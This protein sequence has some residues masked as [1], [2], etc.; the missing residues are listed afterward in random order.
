[1]TEDRLREFFRKQKIKARVDHYTAEGRQVGFAAIGADKLP[2]LLFIHGAPASMTIYKDYFKD[3]ELLKQFQLY[4]VDRP[5][6][7]I[8]GEEPE[9]SL[10]K[11]AA[12]ICPLAQRIHRVHQ[13][14]I[15]MAGS[16]GASVACR[17]AMDYPGLAQGLLLIAPSLGPGL[18]KMYW[19]TAL[20]EKTPLKF[21][22]S[23]ESRSATEEKWIHKKELEQ[24]LPLWSRINIPVFYLQA[25][26]DPLIYTSNADFAKKHLV[27]S[28]MLRM[29]FYPHRKHDITSAEHA[30][31]RNKILELYRLLKK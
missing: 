16:Y 27:N 30:A 6:Y 10:Q 14:L 24:M 3:R 13:P 7:G 28:P 9:P 8:S 20:L 29:Y 26:K 4:A 21:L 31:I 11:Q 12:M 22:V 19:F 2:A 17:L 25:D 5:G 23:A 15:I 18:E 1:M